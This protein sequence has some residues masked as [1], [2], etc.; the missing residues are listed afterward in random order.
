MSGMTGLSGYSAGPSG[1]FAD[2]LTTQVGPSEIPEATY[3]RPSAE[4]RHKDS[5]PSNSHDEYHDDSSSRD[6]SKKL[7][8]TELV[9]DAKTKSSTQPHL[10]STQ[11]GKVKFIFNIAKCDKYLMSY[12]RK[13]VTPKRGGGVN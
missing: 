6:E 13:R 8:V 11:N 7:H 9:W 10:H 2:R 12:C 4:G 3:D 1:P 5:R